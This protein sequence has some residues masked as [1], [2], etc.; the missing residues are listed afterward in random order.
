MMNE[1]LSS[2]MISDVVTV[3]PKDNMANV[4]KLL[5]DNHFHHLPVVEGETLVGIISTHDLLKANLNCDQYDKI[6]VKEVMTKSIARLGPNEHIGA[7]AQVFLRQLFQA[8]PIVDDDDKLLGIVTTIDILKYNF[9]KEY[10]NDPFVKA[11]S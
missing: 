11:N 1:P 3:T 6:L 4:R 8:L 9:F 7:A 5:A 10:P 2:I